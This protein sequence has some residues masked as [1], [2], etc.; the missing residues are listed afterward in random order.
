MTLPPGE[1]RRRGRG[2]AGAG[3]RRGGERRHLARRPASPPEARRGRWGGCRRRASVDPGPAR[4]RRWEVGAS[5]GTVPA[6]GAPNP[7]QD[8]EGGAWRGMTS[9]AGTRRGGGA[10]GF[11]AAVSPWQRL[12]AGGVRDLLARAA[13]GSG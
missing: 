11:G 12:R 5:P 1:G 7:L 6:R 8:G 13:R 4:R 3:E 10:D 9:S 2:R